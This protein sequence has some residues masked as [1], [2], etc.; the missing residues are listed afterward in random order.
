MQNSLQPGARRLG[1]AD[2]KQQRGAVVG[3]DAVAGLADEPHVRQDLVDFVTL[4]RNAV[5][6]DQV[7]EMPEI[8]SQGDRSRR[9]H[10]PRLGVGRAEQVGLCNGQ[11]IQVVQQ[12]TVPLVEVHVVPVEVAPVVDGTRASHGVTDERDPPAGVV[13]DVAGV[14]PRVAAKGQDG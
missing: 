3:H 10:R 12:G 7:D 4:A 11:S 9:Q 14:V 8:R 6:L 13:D 5:G 1:I 2:V